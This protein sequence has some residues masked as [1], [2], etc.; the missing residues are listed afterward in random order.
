MKQEIIFDNVLKTFDLTINQ[1]STVV[2]ELTFYYLK[3]G[4]FNMFFNNKSNDGLDTKMRFINEYNAP[5]IIPVPAKNEKTELILDPCTDCK[6]EVISKETVL[7]IDKKFNDIIGKLVDDFIFLGIKDISA[8]IPETFPISY[9]AGE[10]NKCREEGYIITH[11]KKD[12]KWLKIEDESVK[13]FNLLS[14]TN[15]NYVPITREFWYQLDKG[16]KFRILSTKDLL[17]SGL[18]V[19]EYLIDFWNYIFDIDSIIRKK[20]FGDSIK[21]LY[22]NRASDAGN[23]NYSKNKLYGIINKDFDDSTLHSGSDLLFECLVQIGKCEK[24]TFKKAGAGRSRYTPLENILRASE[25][26]SKTVNL[27]ESW[28]KLYTGAFLVYTEDDNTPVALIPYGSKK[29]TAFNFKT[30]TSEVITKENATQFKKVA[31]SFFTPFPEKDITAKSMLLFGLQF[32]KRDLINFF[33]LGIISTLIALLIPI[34]IGYIFNQ[35]IPNSSINELTQIAIVLIALAFSMGILDF[36]QAIS[37]LRLG[38]ILTYK[39]QS[40]IW[41]R[42]LSLKVSF[43]QKF[44]AGN[45]AERSMGIDKIQNLLS[46][47]VLNAFVSFIFSF[48]FLALLFYYSIELALVGL[49]LGLII[50]AFTI[51]VSYIAYKHVMIIRY[52][53]VVISGFVYQVIS[54]INKIRVTRSEERVFSQWVGKF[55]VQKQHYASKKKVNVAGAVFGSFFPIFSAFFIFM[56]VIHLIT[57]AEKNFT[58]GDYIAFNTAFLSFQGA[59]LRMAMATVPIL[60]TKPLF[61]MFKP[62]IEA[63]LEYSKESEDPGELNGDISVSNVSFKYNTNQPLVV[64]DVSFR[65]NAGE[66][67]ALVG[68]SGSGK[69]TLIRLLLGF[70][71]PSVGQIQYSDKSISHIKIRELR[72]QIS[73]VLQNEKLMSGTVLYNIIGKSLLTEEDAWEAAKLAGCYDDINALPAKMQTEV[74]IGD[75][76]L[77]GGQIQRIVIASAFVKKNKIIFFD[78]ATSALDNYSQKTVSQSMDNMSATKIVIAHRLSTVKKANKIFV[79]DKGR[80]IESGSFSELMAKKG[81]FTELVKEQLV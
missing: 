31:Y 23:L 40:A 12:V 75:T 34:S 80:I 10:E 76:I 68:G 1:K 43:F 18:P 30:N 15:S 73:V 36:V 9:V 14:I 35:I 69:S 28:Y 61:N 54:G 19:F 11:S 64:N 63:E 70:E 25:V 62:I 24:I 71:E 49:L 8:F 17:T 67:I 48:F 58:V 60:T 72:S 38:G 39:L 33:I 27:A 57:S 42:L 7:S 4:T 16:S 52:L 59:L 55:S 65:I 37:V 41:D 13:L 66:Y 53:D 22:A 79:M 50:V 26:R 29:Y 46:G 21:Q 32:V 3:S 51:I 77:S 2:D 81:H 44:D 20:I 47:P 56:T 74:D 6:I 78:E 45:L 5:C